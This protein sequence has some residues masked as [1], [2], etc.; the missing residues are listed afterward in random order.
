[1]LNFIKILAPA[2]ELLLADRQTDMT[3]LI[4][5][6]RSFSNAPKKVI[7]KKNIGVFSYE[8]CITQML[9]HPF[10]EIQIQRLRAS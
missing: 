4:V 9:T 3:K 2:A 6:F 7:F 1:M 5:A 10:S 8:S